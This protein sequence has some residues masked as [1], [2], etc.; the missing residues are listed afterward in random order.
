ML[1]IMDKN[2]VFLCPRDNPGITTASKLV[3]VLTLRLVDS[4]KLF[5][6][7]G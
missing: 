5:P 1:K 4:I 3:V 7:A 2:S 6:L